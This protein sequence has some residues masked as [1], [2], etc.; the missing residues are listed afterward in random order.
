MNTKQ[1][2]ALIVGLVVWGLCFAYIIARV[3]G[4]L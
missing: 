1:V 2:L 4:D 3:R